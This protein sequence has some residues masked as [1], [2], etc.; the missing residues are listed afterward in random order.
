MD[1]TT[2]FQGKE[3]EVGKQIG[4]NYDNFE[5]LKGSQSKPLLSK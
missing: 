5:Q 1:T 2:E 4:I 3:E